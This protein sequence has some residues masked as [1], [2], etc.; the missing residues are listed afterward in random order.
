MDKVEEKQLKKLLNEV[1][2]LY[3]K[4]LKQGY[5]YSGVM[6]EDCQDGNEVHEVLIFEKE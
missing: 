4:H 6:F 2:R 3:K 1:I 5:E